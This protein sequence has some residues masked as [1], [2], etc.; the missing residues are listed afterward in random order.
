MRVTVQFRSRVLVKK[1]ENL[2]SA[3]CIL[4][5][6]MF[7]TYILY[8]ATYNRFYIGQSEDIAARLQRHNNKGV[9]S[10]KPYVPWQL[11]Y[12]EE[13]S[14]RALASNREL[15]IKRK[16]SRSYI[17]FLVNGG[18]TGRHVPM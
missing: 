1:A 4:G 5:V 13:Y 9:P 12:Y 11:V 7:Y 3:F 10:T 16:K 14:S 15:E 2:F 17:E 18:G 6:I 8:S